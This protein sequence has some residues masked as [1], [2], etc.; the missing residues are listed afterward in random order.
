MLPRV[1][2]ILLPTLALV[3]AIAPGLRYNLGNELEDGAPGARMSDMIHDDPSVSKRD[4]NSPFTKEFLATIPIG[5]PNDTAEIIPGPPF[6]PA[7]LNHDLT[8][9]DMAMADTPADSQDILETAGA[10]EGDI[11]IMKL[12]EILQRSINTKPGGR[13][14]IIDKN[15]MW[16]NRKIPYLVANHYDQKERDTIAAAINVINK[17]SCVK[18]VDHDGEHDYITIY[19]G[20]GCSSFIGSIGGVQT[21][22]I[23]N[24]CVTAGIV[25]HELM[26]A[27]GFW[28]EQSRP[29][30]DQFI[31]IDWGN[32]QDGMD[33]NFKISPEWEVQTLGAA[34]DYG[35]IMHYGKNAFA[36]NRM[37]NTITPKKNGANIGQRTTYSKTDLAK[38]NKLYEC[39]GTIAPEPTI[40]VVGPCHDDSAN[41]TAWASAG[42]CGKNPNYMNYHCQKSCDT[43]QEATCRDTN[44]Y[45]K[46]WAGKGECTTNPVYME[47]KCQLSCNTCNATCKDEHTNCGYWAE[48]GECQINPSYMIRMCKQSCSMCP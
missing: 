16:Q 23:G 9:E 32:I 17:Q 45:C 13:N 25:M 43:C 31:T 21:V 12:D 22:S 4:G 48:I 47:N 39:D 1:L 5:L 24:G 46:Y 36:K 14:A 15:K 29:D 28:H 10:F 6:T 7:E 33:H 44:Q 41:C 19:K 40:P 18:L 27:I 2:S 37:K 20:Q 26:H 35:S 34:Y 11:R 30:R 38:I 8:Q 42:E 3:A